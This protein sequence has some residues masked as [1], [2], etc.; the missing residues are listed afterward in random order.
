MKAEMQLKLKV[1]SEDTVCDL[2]FTVEE[3]GNSG[4]TKIVTIPVTVK[5]GSTAAIKQ[6][7]QDALDTYLKPER[8]EYTTYKK[9]GESLSAITIQIMSDT[10]F[11]FRM[12]Q[13]MQ[14]MA[15]KR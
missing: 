2:S 6:E 10:V 11:S 1:P 15:I 12:Y 13:A 14:V 8:I 4:N 9:D 5:D 7:L 3:V